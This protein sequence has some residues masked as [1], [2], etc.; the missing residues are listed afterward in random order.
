MC[1]MLPMSNTNNYH[2]SSFAFRVPKLLRQ[3]LLAFAALWSLQIILTVEIFLL[4]FFKMYDCYN[5]SIS[6][7]H[8]FKNLLELFIKEI[9]FP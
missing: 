4:H 3:I 9:T 8:T 1:Y 6:F 2:L 7:V 5:K